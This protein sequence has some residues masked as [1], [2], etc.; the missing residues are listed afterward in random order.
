MGLLLISVEDD[1]QS[2][3]L[4][5]ETTAAADS[6]FPE[7]SMRTHKTQLTQ[8][9]PGSALS[10]LHPADSRTITSAVRLGSVPF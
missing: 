8:T 3:A 1:N 5:P 10:S 6:S 7:Q 9:V 2:A 4:Y